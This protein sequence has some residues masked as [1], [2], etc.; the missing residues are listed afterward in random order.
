MQN[1][2]TIIGV[3]ELHQNG[4]SYALILIGGIALLIIAK[5][6]KSPAEEEE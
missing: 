5:K 3:V 4:C 1:F 6:R 2:S